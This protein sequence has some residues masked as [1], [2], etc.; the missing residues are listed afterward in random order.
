MSASEV[1]PASELFANYKQ[2]Y[3]AIMWP[4]ASHEPT[5]A[6][7]ERLTTKYEE[8]VHKPWFAEALKLA[9]DRDELMGMLRECWCGWLLAS[10]STEGDCAGLLVGAREFFEHYTKRYEGPL[11]PLSAEPVPAERVVTLHQLYWRLINDPVNVRLL[12][13]AAS[14]EQLLRMLVELWRGSIIKLRGE[15]CTFGGLLPPA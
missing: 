7:L 11:M 4:F 15:G 10:R 5:P 12:R 14:R 2:V 1:P 8:L 6:E 13:V 3:G 9:R